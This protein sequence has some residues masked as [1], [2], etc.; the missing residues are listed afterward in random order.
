MRELGDGDKV[1]FVP[2]AEFFMFDDARFTTDA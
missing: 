2:E 1:I